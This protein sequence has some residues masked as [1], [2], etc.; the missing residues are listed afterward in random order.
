MYPLVAFGVQLMKVDAAFFGLASIH[1]LDG[2]AKLHVSLPA[3]TP[4]RFFGNFASHAKRLL[5]LTHAGVWGK[6]R[7][8][9]T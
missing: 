7:A 2:Q 1:G 8:L 6:Y 3:S 9:N 4:T 5:Y